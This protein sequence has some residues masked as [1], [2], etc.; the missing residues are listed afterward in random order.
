MSSLLVGLLWFSSSALLSTWANT[1]FLRTFADPL[2]HTLIRFAGS[3]ILGTVAFLS[4][5]KQ[6]G[7]T[8]YNTCLRVI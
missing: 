6:I 3:A 8:L 2:L 4:G 5:K 7:Q 1:T